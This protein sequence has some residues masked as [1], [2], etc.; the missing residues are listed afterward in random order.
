MAMKISMLFGGLFY[1]L[2]GL[3]VAA[4]FIVGALF[5]FLSVHL[6]VAGEFEPR[7]AEPL[8][9][10]AAA[11]VGIAFI[12][13]HYYREKEYES[14]AIS[15]VGTVLVFGMTLLFY[16]SYMHYIIYLAYLLLLLGLVD[17][18]LGFEYHKPGHHG[19]KKARKS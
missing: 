11:S 12:E 19:R 17:F 5:A 16:L 6:T 3:A 4:P 13:E 10:L 14:F 9:I 7:L 1:A 18:I 15:L 8:W 2:R